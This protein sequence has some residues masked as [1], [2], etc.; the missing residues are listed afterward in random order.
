MRSGFDYIIVGAGSA[1]CVLA[2]RL[3]EDPDTRVL[4]IEAGGSDRALMIDMPAGVGSLLDNPKFNW[5]FMTEPDATIGGR[6]VAWPRGRVLGG[7][8]SINGMAY[9]RGHALDYERWAASGCEGW[10]Y[11]QVLPYFKRAETYAGRQSPYRGTDGPL[12]VM[13]GPADNPIYQAYLAA[14]QQAGFGLTEDQ[15]GYRQEGFGRMDMTIRRGRRQSASVAYLRPARTRPNL[16]VMTGTAVARIIVEKS[17]ARGVEILRGGQRVRLEAEGEVL[18]CAGTIQSPQLL[19]LSGIGDPD[20]LAAHGLKVEA[21]LPEVGAN[22]QDHAEVY[23]QFACLK[24]VSLHDTL[25]P[26]RKLMAGIEWLLFKSGVAA[27]NHSE[28][29]AFL[30]VGQGASHPDIQ[31]HFLPMAFAFDTKAPLDCHSFQAHISPMRQKS[32][33]RVT[34]AGPEPTTPPR[35]ETNYYAEPDDL[36]LM[37]EAL[38]VSRDVFHQPAFDELRG[39]ELAPGPGVGSRGELEDFLR[40]TTET[41]FHPCGTA[42]MGVDASAVVDPSGRVHGLSR[43]RVVD[44]SIMPDIVSGNLNAPVIMMA[45]K[46]ADDIRGMEPLAPVVLP[47]ARAGGAA[48]EAV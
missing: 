46:I 26:H 13:Q 18:L 14:G 31:H 8:S 43:L 35:I 30:T 3:S 16:T 10:S 27:T 15:N 48:D 32:R 39:E 34:L 22:L 5:R 25:R 45:E 12:H 28:A 33:G 4:L 6:R 20:Q 44:A 7:S 47:Y 38:K 29:G 41:A 40:R 2:A 42:R 24:P 17:V 23:M 36:A 11:S 1:G 9:V 19:M 21:D 37:V